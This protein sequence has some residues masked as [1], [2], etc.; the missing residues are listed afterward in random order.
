LRR[1]RGIRILFGALPARARRTITLDDG[2]EVFGHE[3]FPLRAYFCDP[4][5]LWQ[6]G[7]VEH[8]NSG[9]RRSLPRHSRLASD[10]DADLDNTTPRKCLG[11]QTTPG[12]LLT[13]I[14]VALHTS[15]QDLR[16]S[17]ENFSTSRV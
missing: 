11:F 4:R 3:R 17:E 8:T 2:G 12:S 10:T 16:A 5:S 7:S 6:R 9:I 13:S 14:G 15:T 1:L